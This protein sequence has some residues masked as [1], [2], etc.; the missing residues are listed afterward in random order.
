MEH[1]AVAAGSLDF[2]EYVLLD[3]S[4]IS[5]ILL[6]LDVVV[7][8]LYHGNDLENCICLMQLAMHSNKILY[9]R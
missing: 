6:G 2:T 1:F 7:N 8:S 3:A 9:S 4:L 5:T